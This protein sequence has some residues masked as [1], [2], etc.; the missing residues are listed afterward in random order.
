MF[1]KATAARQGDWLTMW[2]IPLPYCWT[3]FMKYYAD[4]E[5]RV[6]DERLK[7]GIPLE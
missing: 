7:R 4:L 2:L 3:D 5:K 1:N 6:K